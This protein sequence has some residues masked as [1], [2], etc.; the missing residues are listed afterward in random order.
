MSLEL[1]GRSKSIL[2]LTLTKSGLESSHDASET[3]ECSS[4]IKFRN[5]PFLKNQSEYLCA[6][7]RFSVP[8]VEVPTIAATG[9]TVYEY[10]TTM[11]SNQIQAA[12]GAVPG[13]NGLT[14]EQKPTPN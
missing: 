6:V 7:T 5:S 11:E 1:G 3:Q 10:H 4:T 14:M 12:I 9:F 8:L 2:Y 13:Y